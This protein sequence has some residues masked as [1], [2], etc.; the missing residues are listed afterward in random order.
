MHDHVKSYMLA[1]A[2]GV[3]ALRALV[4]YTLALIKELQCIPLFGG[5]GQINY[6]N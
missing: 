4:M 3:C 1:A 2:R 5:G 6:G